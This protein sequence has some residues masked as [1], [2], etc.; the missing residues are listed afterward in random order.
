MIGK[1]KKEIEFPSRKEYLVYLGMEFIKEH[2]DYVGVDNGIFY[3]GTECDSLA[4]VED[5]GYEFN[6]DLDEM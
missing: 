3:D 2:G 5:L 1:N 6:I 4:L